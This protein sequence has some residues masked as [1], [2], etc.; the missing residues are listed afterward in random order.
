[1]SDGS[2]AT[3]ETKSTGKGYPA[4]FWRVIR[5]TRDQV[6]ENK[7]RNA[8]FVGTA[9]FDLGERAKVIL[10]SV[11]EGEDKPLKYPHMFRAAELVICN[12]TDLLPYLDFSMKRA[13][14]NLREV[15]TAAATLELSAR[16]GEARGSTIG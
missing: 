7:F 1:L 15:N 10:F 4:A 14:S 5:L 2:S 16:T 11:T 12:K 9:Q 8:I 6:S 13:L 3:A